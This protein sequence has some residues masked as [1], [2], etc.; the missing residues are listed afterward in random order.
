M[1]FDRT[2]T[3]RRV[4]LLHCSDEWTRLTPGIEGTVSFVDDAGTLHVQWDDGSTLG[5]CADA[6]DRWMLLPEGSTP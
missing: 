4:R 5:L 6:G 1:T 3:G 2:Q